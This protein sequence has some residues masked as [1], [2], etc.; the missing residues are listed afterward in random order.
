MMLP[1][2]KE[3]IRRAEAAL[4][5]VLAL[6]KSGDASTGELRMGLGAFK[7]MRAKLDACQTHAA[8][9]LAARERHGDGGAGVLA[10]AAGLSRREAAGQV[11]TARRLQALPMFSGLSRTDRCPSPMRGS[12]L[13]PQ[14]RPAPRPSPTTLNCW[15]RHRRCLRISSPGTASRWSAQRK[16][17]RGRLAAAPGAGCAFGTARTAWSICAASSIRSRAPTS[18]CTSRPKPFA[19]RTASMV[20]SNSA[21]MISAWPMHLRLLPRMALGTGQP[22]NWPPRRHLHRAASQCRRHPGL[23][24]DRR[25]GRDP[26]ERPRRAHVQRPSCGDRVQRQGR[27]AVAR[28]HQDHRDR[29]PV[30]GPHRQVQRMCRL[31]RA[32]AA[33]PG[34]PHPA[35][36]AG[37]CHRH[38]QH[39][40][41][42][43]AL[44][45][46]GAL[47]RLEGRSGRARPPH[48]RTV[49]SHPPRSGSCR[50]GRTDPP[51]AAL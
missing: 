12:W 18:A 50:R 16:A 23:R 44:P 25:R 27:A 36:V 15:T 41:A 3:A 40:P 24:R 37:W 1:M 17:D 22:S 31:W 51:S 8:G 21:A 32:A 2:M 42:V 46:E 45:P 7:S 9:G 11:K 34:P 20:R 43:L 30:Q 47:S 35:G 13:T 5:D 6:C 10:Q 26:P 38:H 48:H 39:D 14:T 4:D 19:G 49:R 28:T 29:G 33:V